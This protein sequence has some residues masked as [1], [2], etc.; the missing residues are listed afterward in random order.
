MGSTD[1]TYRLTQLLNRTYFDTG[2]CCP[3]GIRGMALAVVPAPYP[4]TSV[5]IQVRAQDYNGKAQNGRKWYVSEHA[6]DSEIVMTG[7]AALLAW[8]EHEVREAYTFDGVRPGNPHWDVNDLA[9]DPPLTECRQE[10]VL[11]SGRQS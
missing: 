1:H 3:K 7:L 8:F 6:C 11:A 4:D 10:G 2:Q 5:F 9:Q